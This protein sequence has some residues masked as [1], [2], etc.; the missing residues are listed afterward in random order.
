MG[1]YILGT[2]YIILGA[3]L[4]GFFLWVWSIQDN[5]SL[6]TAGYLTFIFSIAAGIG[7]ITSGIGGFMSKRWVSLVLSFSVLCIA[8]AR[9]YNR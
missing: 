7:L 3:G 9:L 1:K 6:D 4:I 2:F 8:L 5:F